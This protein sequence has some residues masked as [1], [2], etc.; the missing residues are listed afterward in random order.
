MTLGSTGPPPFGEQLRRLRVGAGLTQ[1]ALAQRSRVSVDAI[2]AL[3][4]GRRQRPRSDT[5]GMLGDALGL[6][7]FERQRLAA[8]ARGPGRPRVA[9][10]R[11]RRAAVFLSH[12]SDLRDHPPDRSYVAAAEAAVT[13][14]GHAVADMA[15]FAASDAEPAAYC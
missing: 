1:E 7:A 14:A 6:D 15:Y 12:T 3:E 4:N 10:A 9:G 2:S 13:R 5:L 8:S 11:A